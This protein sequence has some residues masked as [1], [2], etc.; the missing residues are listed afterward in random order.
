MIT[1]HARA[2][3]IAAAL[4]Q[5]GVALADE[6][7]CGS[8]KNAYGPF[9]YRSDFNRKNKIPIVEGAH[10]QP[11]VEALQMGGP[12]YYSHRDLIGGLDYTL[13]A[14]PN[15][16]RAL[17]ALAR[18]A[19]RGWETD[20]YRTAD[21]YFDRAIRFTPDDAQVRMIYGSYLHRK[22]DLKGALEQYTVAREL[23]PGSVELA[24]NFG[25]LY[26]DMG[27]KQ[28]AREEAVQAYSGGYPL[29][30]LR[31]KLA[32]AGLWSKDD[33]QQVAQAQKSAAEAQP[34]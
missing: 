9:D 4:L 20:P 28:K 31:D 23:L 24:Y 3:I 13:R 1:L 22:K 32:R 11:E 14:I 21:C 18:Y 25:L 8:L 16:H 15:H 12:I 6:A 29:P 2:L 34:Q 7:T 27:D 10:F 26:L 19:L 5:A 17:S 33:D 30:G